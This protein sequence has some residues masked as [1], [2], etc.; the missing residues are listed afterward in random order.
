MNCL[1]NYIGLKGIDVVPLSGLYLNQLPGITLNASNKILSADTLEE[2][3]ADLQKRAAIRLEKDLRI[4]MRK[5]YKLKAVKGIGLV[6]PE[7]DI[8]SNHAAAARYRGIV[9]DTGRKGSFLSFQVNTI[10]VTFPDAVGA[11][12]IKIFDE[13]GVELDSIDVTGVEGRNVYNVAKKYVA[14]KLFIGINATAVPLYS[15]ELPV[16]VVN[17]C[18][19]CICMIC[20]DC[21]PAI[22]GAESLIS[23]PE[24][25]DK[26]GDTYGME[27]TF[28]TVCDYASI[29]CH[30][31][32][33]FLDVW[34]YL[35]AA[36]MMIE[37][38]Y[39][40]RMNKFTT[41]DR[42][43]AIELNNHFTVEYE[44]ALTET[45]N[46]LDIED[47]D[48]CLECNPGITRREVLP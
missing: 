33:E 24:V 6:R 27:L 15:S 8:T 20:D 2:L 10:A 25:T 11:V 4:A 29:V 5:R 39:S 1:T 7:I 19:E 48:C 34:Q 36:E 18:C 23:T 37:R 40:E 31:K 21:Q 14:S 35:L 16:D 9:I 22:Y 26:T 32:P 17:K 46:A 30:N 13:Y 3:W 12:I 41:I 44:K 42:D 38:T 47:D 45:V 43:G 28:S